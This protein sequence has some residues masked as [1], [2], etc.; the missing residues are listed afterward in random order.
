MERRNIGEAALSIS[1]AHLEAEE[2]DTAMNMIDAAQQLI[3]AARITADD[4]LFSRYYGLRAR[5][6]LFV[7]T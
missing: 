3:G 2:C 1:T 5:C 7:E 4:G 6:L